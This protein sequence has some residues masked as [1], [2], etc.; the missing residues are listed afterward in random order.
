[1]AVP[2]LRWLLFDL[3]ACRPMFDP[4]PVHDGFM[5]EKLSLVQVVSQVHLFSPNGII[6]AVLHSHSLLCHQYHIMLVFDSVI[7]C[8]LVFHAQ[9]FRGLI[10]ILYT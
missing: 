3:S 4:R 6:S 2:W 9:S 10:F 8:H 5:V 1:M 7:K